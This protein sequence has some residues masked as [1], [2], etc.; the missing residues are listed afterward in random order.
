M[1]KFLANFSHFLPLPKFASIQKI[2]DNLFSEKLRGNAKNP[3]IE[4]LSIF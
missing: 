4:I 1:S 2:C 3:L